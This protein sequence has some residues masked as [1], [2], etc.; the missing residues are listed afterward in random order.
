MSTLI[1][2]FGCVES[3]AQPAN[4]LQKEWDSSLSD[5]TGWPFDDDFQHRKNWS[6]PK[7]KTPTPG[8]SAKQ[9]LPALKDF[10]NCR[11]ACSLGCRT[12]R[13][14]GLLPD[15][16]GLCWIGPCQGATD[17]LMTRGW[18]RVPPQRLMEQ[19]ASSQHA[20]LSLS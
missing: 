6:A 17:V 10:L 4:W 19:A 9:R 11:P 20:A 8:N 3:Q 1:D 18:R 2:V 14:F 7:E 12:D 15:L 13:A 5:H 16:I